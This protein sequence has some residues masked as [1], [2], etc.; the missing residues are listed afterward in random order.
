MIAIV[1]VSVRTWGAEMA[2]K[3]AKYDDAVYWI[4][5][6]DEPGENDANVL[7]DLI[8]IVL[9]ADIFDR[10]PKAVAL[11]VVRTRMMIGAAG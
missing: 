5:R 11:D 8:S 4:A 10:D 2:R 6:N 7:K 1:N 3:T 9:T